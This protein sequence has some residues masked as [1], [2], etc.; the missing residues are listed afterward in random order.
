[1]FVSFFNVG[2]KNTQD[3]V[4]LLFIYLYLIVINL[5]LLYGHVQVQ[6]KCKLKEYPSRGQPIIKYHHKC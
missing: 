3:A 4:L 6:H 5:I 1:M 2:H